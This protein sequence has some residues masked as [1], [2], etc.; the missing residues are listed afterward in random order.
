MRREV[1]P[2]IAYWGNGYIRS[3]F[4]WQLPRTILERRS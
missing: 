1:E 2:L 3:A 4:V